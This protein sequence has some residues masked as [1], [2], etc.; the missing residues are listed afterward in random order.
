M[1]LSQQIKM[2]FVKGI[3]YSCSSQ[4]RSC[5]YTNISIVGCCSASYECHGAEDFGRIC[6]IDLPRFAKAPIK[7]AFEFVTSCG[8]RI[9]KLGLVKL[10][11]V[12]FTTYQLV[13]V[14]G[15][16]DSSPDRSPPMTWTHFSKAFIGKFMPHSMRDH[17]RKKYTR[18]WQ[19]FITVVEYEVRFH[20][21]ETFHNDSAHRL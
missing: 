12:D 13:V 3:A 2:V 20:D 17:L 14:R 6:E 11:R 8:E 1:V 5:S 4:S 19:G 10:H 18:L 9:H 15:Y 21:L 16:L 7:D